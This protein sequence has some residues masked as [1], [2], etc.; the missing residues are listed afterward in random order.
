MTLQHHRYSLDHAALLNTLALRQKLLIIQDLDGVCMGL[1]R[2]P[3]TRRIERQYVEAAR[4]LAGQFYVLTNGEHTGSRGV[5]R[6]VEQCFDSADIP[7]QQGLY[8]PGLAGGGVQWQNCYGE[9]AHPGVSEAEMAFLRAVP[10]QAA[11]FLATT[12]AAPP[13]NLSR[14]A[15]QPLIESAVLDNL[16]SPTVNINNAYQLWQ[17]QPALY[18]TLQQQLQ[19]FMDSLLRQASQQQLGDAFFVHYAPNLGSDSKGC[20]R[21]K[22]GDQQSAGTTDFQFMLKG[23]VKEVG[24]LVLLNRYYYQHTGHYPLGEGFNARQASRDPEALLQL[25]R[26][27][28]APE[29]M[30]CIVGVGDTVTSVT[31]TSRPQPQQLR[32]GSDRGFL[33]LVQALGETFGTDNT[34]LYIDSSQGEVRRAGVDA[35]QLRHY[36]T[37]PAAEPWPALTGI[38]DANDALKLNFVFE[39]GHRQYVAFF[40]ALARRRGLQRPAPEECPTER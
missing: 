37:N 32:G 23:A 18:L 38:S 28:F 7:R 11:Q 14:A 24:V 33:T 4:Q 3:L 34:V 30:P 26:R 39:Q 16:V 40:N 36:A 21:I 31:D 13:F 35:L 15:A 2:D 25:A 1:V 6:L 8:L 27:H 17:Q 5:N 12:L 10:Q 29:H 20:E 22:W 9:I 19:S